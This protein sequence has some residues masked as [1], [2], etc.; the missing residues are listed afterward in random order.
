MALLAYG[1]PVAEAGGPA[2]A[3][4]T[5]PQMIQINKFRLLI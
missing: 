1:L 2:G 5:A 4:P 3:M